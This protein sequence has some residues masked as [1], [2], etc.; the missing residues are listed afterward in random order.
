MR[1]PTSDWTDLF[2]AFRMLLDP[3]KLWLAFKGV[4]FSV[5]LAGLLLALFAC[6]YNAL[7][8]PINGAPPAPPLE[9]LD[10]QVAEEAGLQAADTDVLGALLD[11]RLGA[12]ARATRAFACELVAKARSEIEAILAARCTPPFGRL[13]TLWSCQGLA[14]LAVL[15][16][17]LAFGLLFVWSYYG[18]AIMRLTAVEYALGDRLDLRSASAYTRRKHQAFYGPPLGLALA[19]VAIKLLLMAAGFLVWNILLVAVAVIGLLA[20][21]VV[22]AIVRDRTRSTPKA[23]L[24]GLLGLCALAGLLAALGFLGWRIPY[25]GELLIGLL[26]PLALLAGFVATLLALWLICGL[27]LMAGAVAA[28]DVGAFDAW[29]RSFHYLFV[30]PW[31][32]AGYALAALAHGGAC[33]AFVYLVRIATEW[34]ALAPLSMGALAAGTEVSES[35]MG[36]FLTM[37]RVLLDLVF[38]AFCTGYAFTSATVIYFLLRLRADGTPIT[39]VHLEPRDSAR[40]I[41]PSAPPAT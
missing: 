1:K 28:S 8:I 12:A 18:A 30:H 3:R 39:E 36:F 11:G 2:L 34:A 22:A 31:R 9:G 25:A 13:A 21:G 27:P 40:L 38:L 7:G 4:L 19:I 17:L 16:L 32:Y 33:L 14:A 5:A 10:P 41:P 35:L 23:A 37:N 15:E 6:L 24:A 26:S 20:I 29:S